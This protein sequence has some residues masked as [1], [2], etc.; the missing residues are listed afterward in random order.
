MSLG[1]LALLTLAA[2]LLVGAVRL[3]APLGLSLFRRVRAHG[4]VQL[5]V[6]GSGMWAGWG[7]SVLWALREKTREER[8]EYMRPTSG[9][10]PADED[11]AEP[12][13]LPQR[14]DGGP[15]IP[16]RDV[17]DRAW[18]GALVSLDGRRW[19]SGR[20]W[21]DAE[22]F[23]PAAAP[24]SDD[25]SLWWDGVEWRWVPGEWLGS[26]EPLPARAVLPEPRSGESSWLGHR[27]RDRGR[28]PERERWNGSGR[29]DPPPDLTPR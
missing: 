21:V 29:S 2:A 5:S 13:P 11:V 1:T 28:W 17:P 23:A 8:Y 22:R 4:P 14:V 12:S 26:G 18:E 19:W 3:L 16:P 15:P 9:E 7:A 6:G 24:R 27:D 20:A 10:A 25:G